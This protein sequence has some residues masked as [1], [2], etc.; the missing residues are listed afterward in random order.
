MTRL[1]LRF[2]MRRPTFATSSQEQHYAAALEM[3]RWADQHDFTSVSLSEHH[4]VPDGYLPSPLIM[5]AALL[6]RTQRLIVSVSALLAALADPVRLAEDIAVIDSL[7][8]G[9]L[10]I[11]L[12]LGYRDEEYA[13]FGVEKARRGARLNNHIDVL[14]R[15][16]KGE[17]FSYQDR[18]IRVTP[19]PVTKPHP[20]LFVGGSSVAAARRAARFNLPFLPDRSDVHLEAAYR[21]ACE[22]HGVE[23]VIMM[24]RQPCFVHI[25]ED[26][27][28]TRTMLAEHVVHDAKSYAE[29]Q[30]VRP[31][32]VVFE[33]LESPDDVATSRVYRI[34][35]P[36]EALELAHESG[37]LIFHPLVGGL[38]PELGWQSF[39]LFADKVAPHLAGALSR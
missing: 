39:Q 11:T 6:A 28:R 36:E 21:S 15:A 22:Q 32:A 7:A 31:H 18:Q 19:L 33:A 27:E 12:G 4:A 9:R 29:W 34:V 23:P 5:A 1:M 37:T 17:P 8:P 30:R 20:T 14:L 13:M 26:P 38:D 16:W 2:D 3:A 25:S 35:T 24:P 10:A